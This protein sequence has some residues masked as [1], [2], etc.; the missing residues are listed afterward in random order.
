[1]EDFLIAILQAILECLCDAFSYGPFDWPAEKSSGTL[2][3]K[4]LTLFMVGCGLALISILILKYTWIHFSA[5]R[6]ANLF[7]APLMSAFI[8]Q[9]IARHRS[10]RNPSVIPR[11]HFWQAFWFTLGV[12]TVRFV[13][14]TRR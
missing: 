2:F 1:M 9:A 4:C 14:T 5:L 3:G 11:N 10:K 7:F 12:A 13:C 6:I 8:S